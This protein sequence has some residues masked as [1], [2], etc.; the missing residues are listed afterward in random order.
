MFVFLKTKNFSIPTSLN[1]LSAELKNNYC[2]FWKHIL[3][4]REK[5]QGYE[6]CELINQKMLTM[7]LDI[8]FESNSVFK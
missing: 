7:N 1:N 8:L 3:K 5:V 6:A 2:I 4:S